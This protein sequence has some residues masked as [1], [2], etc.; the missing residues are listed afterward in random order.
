M[1]VF[2]GEGSSVSNKSAGEGHSSQHEDTQTGT[3]STRLQDA[4]VTSFKCDPYPTQHGFRPY[5][6]ALCFKVSSASGRPKKAFIVV[7]E[8]EKATFEELAAYNGVEVL[9]QKLR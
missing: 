7:K 1:E 6:S 5:W 9:W 8:I 2:A 3:F 4:K